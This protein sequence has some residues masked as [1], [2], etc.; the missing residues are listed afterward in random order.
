LNPDPKKEVAWNET[1]HETALPPH[2]KMLYDDASDD[3][4]GSH[5]YYNSETDETSWERPEE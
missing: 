4:E 3:A 1:V 2:W 5:Y